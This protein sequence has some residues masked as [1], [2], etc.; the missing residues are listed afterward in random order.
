MCYR[1]AQTFLRGPLKR[2]GFRNS[3]NARF[4]SAEQYVADR[5]EQIEDYQALFS[6]FSSFAG[7]TV[8]EI[9][10]NKGYLLDSFLRAES[11]NAIGADI[12]ADALRAGQAAFG[13]RIRFVQATAAGLPLPEKSVDVIYTID[14]V[15]HLSRPY[16]ILMEAHR[17]LRPGGTFL[18]HFHPW[19]GPYGSHLED[20]IPF[21]WPHVLFP[22][23]TLLTV[24]ARLYEST[25]YKVACY[26]ID[27][28]TGMKKPNPF[29]DHA[30]WD[31]FLNRM[32]VRQFKRLI[33]RLPFEIVHFEKIGFGGRTFPIARHLRGLAALPGID[34]FLTK[35][36][37][38]VLKKPANGTASVGAACA[39]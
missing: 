32:T 38:C 8:L 14:T 4:D 3:A 23:T 26:Y 17:V 24:A 25:D 30:R 20:I 12:D 1:L 39:L 5:V 13:G 19:L 28:D 6:S 33:R 9:G 18:V 29:L 16:E 11:F 22:M 2:F 36:V 15:E 37:Y 10:C 34:E 21:P 27:P 31:E 35:A 7:K